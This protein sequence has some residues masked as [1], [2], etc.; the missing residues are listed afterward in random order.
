LLL[1]RSDVSPKKETLE[2]ASSLLAFR[3]GPLLYQVS[4]ALIRL[5]DFILPI[6]PHV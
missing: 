4:S 2:E 5:L 6:A 1:S 3:E